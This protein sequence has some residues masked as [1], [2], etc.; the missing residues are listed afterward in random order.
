[1]INVGSQVRL[2]GP[3]MILYAIMMLE[4]KFFLYRKIECVTLDARRRA[5]S[6]RKINNFVPTD[7]LSERDVIKLSTVESRE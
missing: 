5:Q 7:R 2:R 6:R 3:K 1:V 4:F